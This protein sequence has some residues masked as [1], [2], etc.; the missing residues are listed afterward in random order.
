[1]EELGRERRVRGARGREERREEHGEQRRGEGR[2]DGELVRKEV[3]RVREERKEEQIR[4]RK[5]G[6][7]CKRKRRW[8]DLF[9][10]KRKGRRVAA[11]SRGV[12]GKEPGRL[13]RVWRLVGL[14][15]YW[16]SL[17]HTQTSIFFCKLIW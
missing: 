6:P 7:S 4:Q 1:M 13:A 10:K 11:N 8:K 17:S 2:R 3:E 14:G 5:E 15:P 12:G 9:V 16:A